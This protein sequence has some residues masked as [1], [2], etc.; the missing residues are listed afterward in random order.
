M[1]LT[2]Q[3]PHSSFFTQKFLPWLVWLP[4]GLFVLFQFS[5][6]LSSGVMAESWMKDFK[7]GPF[8]VGLLAS[9]YYY[10]YVLLQIPAGILMDHFGP[11]R[12]L[13]FGGFL[14]SLG[15]LAFATTH[16]FYFAE[17][18]RIFMG[19]GASFAFVGSLY[20]IRVWFPPEQYA[21]LVGCVETIGMFGTIAGNVLMAEGMKYFGWRGFMLLAAIISASLGLLV[22]ALVRDKPANACQE[23]PDQNVSEFWKSLINLLKD[24]NV[25]FNSIALSLMFSI[26]TIFVALWGVTFLIETYHISLTISVAA[27]SMVL[28]GVAIGGPMMG[29]LSDQMKRR[30]PLLVINTL[31]SILLL[32][33]ILY[34]KFS[35][36]IPLFLLLL[37]LGV[38]AS[39]YVLSFSVSV[40]IAPP[41][42]HG[43]ALGFTNA[44][45]VVAAPLLQPLLGWMLHRFSGNNVQ[46]YSVIDYRITLTILPL[47]LLVAFIAALCLT[48]THPEYQEAQQVKK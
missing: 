27:N 35:S 29:Y 14:C 26:I 25:W 36:L 44:I 24:R 32:L 37:A 21:T 31:L 20:I 47:C 4:S 34:V 28:V 18:S 17:F 16:T 42:T 40:D 39:A 30:K 33:E 2:P 38:T 41:G 1:S 45:G 15:C 46:T 48:E 7:I 13:T 23:K 11:R 43:S 19:F 5:L 8:A 22:F 12:L 6:Q 10:V 3:Q 9:S